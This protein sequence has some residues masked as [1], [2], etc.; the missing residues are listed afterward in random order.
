MKRVQITILMDFLAD[1]NAGLAGSFVGI[2]LSLCRLLRSRNWMVNLF[3]VREQVQ[4][5]NNRWDQTL[6]QVYALLARILVQKLPVPRI[7]FAIQKLDMMSCA[8]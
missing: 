3:V 8:Q 1:L 7:Q 4:I 6:R 5:S 2:T